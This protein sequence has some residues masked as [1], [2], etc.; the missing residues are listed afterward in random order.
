MNTIKE[1]SEVMEIEMKDDSY[2]GKAVTDIVKYKTDESLTTPQPIFA[3]RCS[4]SG[5]YTTNST[6]AANLK[7][8]LSS[9]SNSSDLNSGGFF[10]ASIG[11]NP[12]QVY[13]L[14]LCRGDQEVTSCRSCLNYFSQTITK[15]C[16]YQKGAFLGNDNC[17]LRFSNRNI[18]GSMDDGFVSLGY[19]AKNA[20]NSVQFND[21]LGN[22]LFDLR[23]RAASVGLR[24]YAAAVVNYTGLTKIY[25]LEQCTPDI[26]KLDCGKCLDVAMTGI[27]I[28]ASGKIGIAV[29]LD[30]GRTNSFNI[31]L[32]HRHHRAACRL[33]QRRSLLLRYQ[34]IPLVRYVLVYFHVHTISTIWTTHGNE[35][36]E[37]LGTSHR[38]QQQ[39][40]DNYYYCGFHS[41]LVVLLCLFLRLRKRKQNIN[42]ESKFGT[43]CDLKKDSKW[44]RNRKRLSKNSGQGELELKNEV[45][46]LAKLQ[47]KNL[48]RLLG[49]CLEKRERLLIYELVAN[50]SLDNFLFVKRAF[51]YYSR[52]MAPEYA[53]RGQFSVESDVFS[54][55]VLVLE[56]ISGQKN[57]CFHSGEDAE[58][59]LSYHSELIQVQYATSYDASILGCY[60][61]KKKLLSDRLW[62]R[63]FSCLNFLCTV[64]SIQNFHFA[65]TAGRLMTLINQQVNMLI[66]QIIRLQFLTYILDNA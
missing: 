21:L 60:A 24:K 41:L 30:L 29:F 4:D 6:Y 62:L 12:D 20:K 13:A 28:R 66:S 50:A 22:L 64:A 25:G 45:L 32:K 10:N 33:H 55:G 46:L 2:Q 16:P 34:P 8:L 49:F 35:V 61:F 65:N 44:T 15:A 26:S 1:F 43:N 18:L 59:L 51:Y 11:K 63:S 17:M 38:Q 47:H 5:N 23:E 39:I 19:N 42:V 57:S 48:V 14:A 31:R 56:T 53:T 58:D 52:Y 9:I 54:F 3:V 40:P 36:L 37:T 27:T 7:T